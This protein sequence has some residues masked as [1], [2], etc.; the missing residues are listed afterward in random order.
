MYTHQLSALL[1]NNH[2]S[3]FADVPSGRLVNLVNMD[4]R[5]LNTAVLWLFRARG[6]CL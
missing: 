5:G 4:L 2:V 6:A 3:R 1:Y